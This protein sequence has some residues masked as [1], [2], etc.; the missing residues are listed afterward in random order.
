MTSPNNVKALRH[1][2]DVAESNIRSLKELG[3]SVEMYGASVLMNKLLRD[4]RLIIG[5]KIG[6]ADWQPDAIMTEL[7]Q[8]IE[9]HE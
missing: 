8:E 1:F 4:L 9:A 5:C 2:H 3:V 7:R 6:E